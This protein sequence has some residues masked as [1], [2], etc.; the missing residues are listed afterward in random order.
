MSKSDT[1][2]SPF[3]ASLILKVSPRTVSRWADDPAVNLTA[4]EVTPGG[5]RRFLRDDVE[6]L[7]A[8]RDTQAVAS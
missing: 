7:A 2:L 1:L 4:V 3:Q 6:R 8:A 5:Q